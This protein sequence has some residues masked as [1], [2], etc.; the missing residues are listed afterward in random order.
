MLDLELK[1]R[2]QG[3]RAWQPAETGLEIEFVHLPGFPANRM[4]PLF[5]SLV[6]ATHFDQA[7]GFPSLFIGSSLLYGL[8]IGVGFLE[9]QSVV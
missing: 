6:L 2:L 1:I 8:G 7:L 4:P 5:D 3:V 9:S